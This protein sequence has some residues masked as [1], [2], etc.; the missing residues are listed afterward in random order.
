MIE[1][2]RLILRRWREEDAASLYKY[3][4]DKRVSELALWPCHT[5][6]EM[7]RMVINEIFI[8]NPYSFAMV[9]KE[10]DEPIGC[11]GLVPTGAE[12]YSLNSS[13]REIGYWI[14]YPYWGKG[15]TTEALG[16]LI[17]Y[18]RDTLGLK[19][20]I[21]TTDS[22]NVASQRVAEKCGFQFIEDYVYEGIPG[23]AYRL[24]A[25]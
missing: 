7:S 23:K 18:C 8:P 15:L 5:S 12:H 25:L 1:T 10:T 2:D 17:G 3:A 14:G 11:I 22:R 20:L 13:E 19:S 9:L 24:L 6:L 16:G 4:S 21:I